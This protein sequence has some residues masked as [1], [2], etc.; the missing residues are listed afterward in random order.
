[1][2]KLVLALAV[3]VS[4]CGATAA[5]AQNETVLST[6]KSICF[7]TGGDQQKALAKAVAAGWSPVALPAGPETVGVVKREKWVGTNHWELFTAEKSFAAG[8]NAPFATHMNVCIV[9]LSPQAPGVHQAARAFMG[10]DPTMTDAANWGWV[11]SEKDGQRT[12]ITSMTP[13]AAA[14]VLT[15][16]PIVIVGATEAPGG[17]ALSFTQIRRADMP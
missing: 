4:F 11:Y 13:E 17:G 14:A 12:A 15:S 16:R 6:F 8:E 10:V 7:E 1:M 9:S 3:A 5:S 2:R